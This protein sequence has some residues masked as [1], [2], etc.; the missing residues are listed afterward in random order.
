MRQTAYLLLFLALTFLFSFSVTA[1][2]KDVPGQTLPATPAATQRTYLPTLMKDEE[3][4]ASAAVYW[5]AYVSNAPWTMDDLDR[6]ESTLEK[7]V[8]ILHFG[9]P[10]MQKGEFKSFPVP[11]M[12]QIRDRGSIP[13][14]GWGSW[15][16]GKGVDQPEFRLRLIADGHYDSFITEWAEAAKAWGHP[17]FLKF[18]WEMNGNWQFPWSVQ[19][20]G[21]QTEDFVAAWH[22]VH[23]IFSAV[24]A[25]NVTWVWCPN[26][27]SRR[28]VDMALLYPGDDYVDWSCL[29]G[30][31]FGGNDWRTFNEVFSGHPGNPFNSYE[32]ILEIAPS[33][34]IMIGEWASAEAGDGG[35]KKAEWIRDAL[36]VQLPQHYPQIHA[37]V[38]FNWNSEDGTSWVINSSSAAARALA[39]GLK[40]SYYVDARFQALDSSPIPSA[41]R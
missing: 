38:W 8:S 32:Q 25:S 4:V 17:F 18:N 19:L 9:L 28:S 20:N 22:R 11:I 1:Q 41:A 2:A 39:A 14:I 7:R 29:H 31:N 30:Y 26:I 15:H 37:V 6:F 36:E 40:S 24:G 10:W 35:A 33:K 16:L 27:A 5:G 34:P 23:D 3:S 12:N 13:M 21:N